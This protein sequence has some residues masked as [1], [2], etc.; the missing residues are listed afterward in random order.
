[1]YFLYRPSINK[2]LT[3]HKEDLEKFNSVSDKFT[4]KLPNGE[5]V[6][7]DNK[8]QIITDKKEIKKILEDNFSSKN[9]GEEYTVGLPSA[10]LISSA[11]FPIDVEKDFNILNWQNSIPSD[12]YKMQQITN[13]LSTDIGTVVHAC[14]EYAVTD[15]NTRIFNKKRNLN[16]YINEVF[17]DKDIQNMIVDFDSRKEYFRD[18]VLKVLTPFFENELEKVD[19]VFSELFLKNEYIQGSID[20]VFYHNHRLYIYDWK[21]SKK[22]QS[23]AMIYH[24]YA[25]QLYIYSRMLLRNGVITKKEYDNLGFKIGFFNWNSGRSAIYEYSK[26]QIDKSRAYVDF[27]VSW[28]WT[29]KN[30]KETIIKL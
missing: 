3:L 18:I 27:L 11:L 2:Y 10:T 29:M 19:P 26:E 13:K 1:M 30:E 21:T 17:E 9:R 12:E 8:F 6:P 28:Y 5:R 16:G 4:R 22:A 7:C 15:R 23:E 14:I 24:K 20:G 25:R